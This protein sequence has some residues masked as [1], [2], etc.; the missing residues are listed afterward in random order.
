[1]HFGFCDWSAQKKQNAVRLEEAAAAEWFFTLL[2]PLFVWSQCD[3]FSAV[4]GALVAHITTCGIKNSCV[5]KQ[6][7]NDLMY[8]SKKQKKE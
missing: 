4:A 5:E 3:D 1:M 7:V 6:H 2:G 8:G